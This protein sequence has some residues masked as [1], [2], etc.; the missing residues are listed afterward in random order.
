MNFRRRTRVETD[1]NLTPLIDVVFLLLIFF[2][3][4]TTFTR[5]TQLKVDLPESVSGEYAD[6]SV[7]QIEVLISV[8]GEVV[9]IDKTLVNPG[10]ASIRAALVREAGSDRS[11]QELSTTDAN[12]PHQAVITAM[13]AAGQEGFS[14]LR[15]TTNEMEQPAP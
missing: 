11:L 14:R 12:T 2:M 13:D 7:Q 4:S 5:E 9:I 6:A 1:I 8:S 15:L 3:V 10:L